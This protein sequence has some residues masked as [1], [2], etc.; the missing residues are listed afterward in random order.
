[1]GCYYSTDN[2]P[3]CTLKV[4]KEK[5]DFLKLH[6]TSVKLPYDADWP[7]LFISGYYGTQGIYY[8]QKG[9]IIDENIIYLPIISQG[10][11]TRKNKCYLSALAPI[12]DRAILIQVIHVKKE[13]DRYEL[14]LKESIHYIKV[15]YSH[16]ISDIGLFTVTWT[17]NNDNVY[18]TEV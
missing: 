1:M 10:C 5:D 15:V 3:Y 13:I 7:F 6:Y 17:V 4:M 9:V 12:N 16:T 14:T 2:E 11:K 18:I 8:I